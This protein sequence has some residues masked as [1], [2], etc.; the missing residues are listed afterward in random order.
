MRYSTAHERAER[1][2]RYRARR[3]LRRD[4]ILRKERE[5]RERLKCRIIKYLGDACER[6]GV[7]LEELGHPAAFDCHHRDWRTK[8]FNICGNHDRSWNVIRAE[9]EK[10]A[11]LCACCH[12]IVEATL[13]EPGRR[14]GRPP[15][16]LPGARIGREHDALRHVAK[17][18]WAETEQVVA[19]RLV[20]ARCQLDLFRT[21]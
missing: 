7:T 2:A 21:P 10:C 9:L 15:L 6:C 17:D 13:E 11:L 1:N 14:R 8:S 20:S 12:R 3:A 19:E 16:P 4:E 18:A 5:R